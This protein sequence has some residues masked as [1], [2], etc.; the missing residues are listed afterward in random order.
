M[1]VWK[2]S[3]YFLCRMQIKKM[4]LKE[5]IISFFPLLCNL[6]FFR[7]GVVWP[8]YQWFTPMRLCKS[9]HRSSRQRPWIWLG[10]VFFAHLRHPVQSNSVW[11]FSS[12][13]IT[14][15]FRDGLHVMG[16]VLLYFSSFAVGLASSK[17]WTTVSL[18]RFYPLSILDIVQNDRH[19]TFVSQWDLC[20]FVFLQIVH[21]LALCVR[22]GFEWVCARHEKLNRKKCRS[23]NGL[24]NTPG[25]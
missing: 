16:F 5:I 22:G 25:L 15:L 10:Y 19:S 23:V 20:A 4:M 12:N 3:G 14:L 21:C 8:M 2:F 24:V 9:V 11:G 6:V 18:S 7:N 1:F 17:L 13:L